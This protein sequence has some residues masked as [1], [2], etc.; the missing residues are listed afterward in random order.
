MKRTR[1]YRRSVTK[2]HI[3][4][5]KRIGRRILGDD[6]YDNDNQYSK[7]KIFC[8]CP[9]CRSY[10]FYL[11]EFALKRFQNAVD[12]QVDDAGESDLKIRIPN[13]F[14]HWRSSRRSHGWK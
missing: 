3:I 12:S 4:R 5:K 13:R 9:M 6:W 11:G 14:I 2:N 7:N 10:N 1:D 8:S